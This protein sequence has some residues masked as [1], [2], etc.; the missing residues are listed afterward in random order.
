M[1]DGLEGDESDKADEPA[2][3]GDPSSPTALTKEKSAVAR[4]YVLSYFEKMAA[5]KPGFRGAHSRRLQKKLELGDFDLSTLIGRGAFGEVRLCTRRQR[6][7]KVMA[8]KKLHKQ[9]MINRNQ[10]Q[11]VRAERDVLV[12]SCQKNVWITDLYY[13]FQDENFLYLVM[14]YV[15]GG[16]LMTWL[17]KYDVFDETVAQFYIAE[18]ILAVHS[19]HNMQYAHRD[20][21]PD[22][23]L[24]DRYGHIKLTDFGLCKQVNVDTIR[25]DMQG[26]GSGAPGVFDAYP[27]AGA[28]S[29]QEKKATWKDVRNRKMF[30]TAVGS[31]GYVAPEVLLKNGYSMDCDWWSVGVILYEMLCGYP[32]FYADDAMQTCHKI[33]KWREYLDFPPAGPDELSP[34]AVNLIAKLLCDSEERLT[35][36]AILS[37]PF[38]EGIL[39]KDLRNQP[40][41][42]VPQLRGASDTRYFEPTEANVDLEPPAERTKD[43]NYLFY[44]FTANIGGQTTR[45]S[46]KHKSRPPIPE[47]FRRPATEEK[48]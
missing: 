36:E 8:I 4:G 21:K 40:P 14:E 20:I 47:E 19:I 12:E 26:H 42:F 10:V 37:H 38:F 2:G 22:N 9:H 17:I 7:H 39:W 3:S 35:F 23:I 25:R 11:H 32:P 6:P 48:T 30:F 28:M 5:N 43:T 24:L 29:Y 15:P 1:L 44:G 41:P 31:P 34:A 45:R 33:I 16:D 18:L 27:T 13:S 46:A